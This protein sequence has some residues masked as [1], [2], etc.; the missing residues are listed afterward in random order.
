[1]CSS[2]KNAGFRFGLGFSF[3]SPLLILDVS[4]N[5]NGE[6]ALAAIMPRI[7]VDKQT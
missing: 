3:E 5:S 7:E 1:M 6:T 2:Q 4:R